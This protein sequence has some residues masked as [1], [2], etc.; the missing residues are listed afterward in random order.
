MVYRYTCAACGLVVR[1]DHQ[2]SGKD[3]VARSCAA[4][5]T[6]EVEQEES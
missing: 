1:I 5:V 3:V 4:D 6:E 2:A